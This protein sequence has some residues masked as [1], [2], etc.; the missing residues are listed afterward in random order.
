VTRAEG[1]WVQSLDGRPALDVYRET[2]R[3]PLAR[4]LRR[5]LGFVLAA[6]PRV[7]GA[8]LEPATPVVR[9]VAGIAEGRRAF[10][11]PEPVV[12][13]QQI[14]FVLRDADGAREDLRALL[15]RLGSPR[16]AC[17]LY[18]DC[19]ERGAALFGVSGLEA[20][21]LE[22]ELPGVPVLGLRGSCEI[23]PVGGQPAL[24]THAAVLAL[25][26]A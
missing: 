3:G 11:L 1:H 6:V 23:G 4:D 24:L 18:L 10:V 12:R 20:A 13:G 25:L 21:Y 22:R 5:A 19:R 7:P 8:A 15:A 26:P 16:P 2:A 9:C 14:A 17:G